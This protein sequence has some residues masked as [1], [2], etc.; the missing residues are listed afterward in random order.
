MSYSQQ[1]T[2]YSD[3]DCFV[4][5]SANI[6]SNVFPITGEKVFTGLSPDRN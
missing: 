3:V 5:V 4:S 1:K 2:T 6:F